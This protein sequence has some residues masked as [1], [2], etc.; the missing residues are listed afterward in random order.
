M[1]YK[2]LADSNLCYGEGRKFL[3][4]YLEKNKDAIVLPEK[5]VAGKIVMEVNEMLNKDIKTMGKYD[6]VS[7]LTPVDHIHSQYLVFDVK[8]SFI[9]SIDKK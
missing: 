4:K 6:W 9:D 1:A 3:E 8:Q 2:K 7:S 5:P